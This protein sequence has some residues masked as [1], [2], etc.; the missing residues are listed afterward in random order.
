[1]IGHDAY[2]RVFDMEKAMRV[3]IKLQFE[4]KIWHMDEG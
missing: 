2:H 3:A 4:I 1:M